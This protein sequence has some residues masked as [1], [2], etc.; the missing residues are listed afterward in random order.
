MVVP[1]E[2][3]DF[4]SSF[5]EIFQIEGGK[6][7]GDKTRFMKKSRVEETV[8]PPKESSQTEISLPAFVLEESRA[9][10]ERSDSMGNSSARSSVETYNPQ[11]NESI[12]TQISQNELTV[13]LKNE[14]QLR[15]V[16]PNKNP[17]KVSFSYAQ[18]D[19]KKRVSEK[20]IEPIP[21]QNEVRV[22]VS[23]KAIDPISM[24][25]SRS[26]SI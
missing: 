10:S 14:E 17:I 5:D 13:N 8:E 1:E 11:P 20:I 18:D 21:I 7:S 3:T 15:P 24:E 4:L 25:S 19:G 12:D 22:L 2:K 9:K 16:T 26:E 23:E 6:S